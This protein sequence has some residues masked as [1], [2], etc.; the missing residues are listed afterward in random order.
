MPET[1]NSLLH[2]NSILISL[3][4]LGLF[5]RMLGTH[6]G[7]ILFHPDEQSIA[8]AAER[9]VISRDFIPVDHSYGALLPLLYALGDVAIFIPVTCVPW[10]AHT[11]ISHERFHCIAKLQGYNPID[12][13]IN[14]FLYWSRYETAFIS[15]CTIIAVYA[16]GKKLFSKEIG[17][18]AAFF[19][20][21]NYRHVVSSTLAL[22]DAP[23]ALFAVFSIVSSIDMIRTPSV[24]NYAKAGFF[25][26][27]AFSVKYFIYVLP[28]FL[29]CHVMALYQTR[30]DT[31]PR[32]K[33]LF[34]S[35]GLLVAAI[36]C[37][38][39]F[40]AINPYAVLDYNGLVFQMNYNAVRYGMASPLAR[41]Y[42]FFW[43]GNSW[44]ALLP[45]QYLYRYGI[46]EIMSVF[47][48]IGFLYGIMKYTK[49]TA[50]LAFT[51]LPFLYIFM[52]VSSTEN[53][54]NYASI[55]PVMMIFPAVCISDSFRGIFRRRTRVIL[56]ICIG[57]MVG[58]QS[59][60]NSFLSSYYFSRQQSL[61]QSLKWTKEHLGQVNPA[62][63]EKTY[64]IP[65]TRIDMYG[66]FDIHTWASNQYLSVDEMKKAGV[67]WAIIG[68]TYSTLRN[69]QLVSNNKHILRM[70]MMDKT[71]IWNILRQTHSSLMLSQL[72]E[73]RV[74]EFVKPAWESLVE[75]S[76]MII[77]VPEVAR[78]T[79]PTKRIL[80]DFDT[81][82]D[83]DSFLVQSPIPCG[84]YDTSVNEQEGIDD[85]RALRISDR[86]IPEQFPCAIETRFTSLLFPVDPQTLV[87]VTAVARIAGDMHAP[88]GDGF[89]RMDLYTHDKQPIKTYVSIQLQDTREWQVMSLWGRVPDDAR[90]ASIGF[91]LDGYYPDT[92][93]VIDDIQIDSH[94]AS[95]VDVSVYP[96]YGKKLPDNFVWQMQ[97]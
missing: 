87:T 26:A 70:A 17:L 95:P 54:R 34:L 50:I 73:Y 46:G 7:Y 22:A 94:T 39:T 30:M 85:S 59:A 78:L 56:L 72:G 15:A 27:L 8:G 65:L 53:V 38:G 32:I 43:L 31:I 83:Y 5:L 18:L 91:Q 86:R 64:D 25:L 23:A 20:A 75:P 16:L 29:L 93:Y 55:M 36:V 24:K 67:E 76:V 37:V 47:V 90:Y 4:L 28:T 14:Y 44:R 10:A 51:I 13:S 88:Q 92:S 77:K 89:M 84:I 1:L 60:T 62:R 48:V 42:D 80:I 81:P 74:E 3:F 96:F 49:Q 66:T 45:L 33:K 82:S 71:F 12:T 97:L 35:P 21:V 11:L 58:A 61:V 6:P 69:D 41:S 2:H 52:V 63:I 68:S 79:G 40:I 19:T 57:I 9:M